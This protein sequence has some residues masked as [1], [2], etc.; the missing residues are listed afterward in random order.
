MLT[1]T[2]KPIFAILAI[3]CASSRGIPRGYY[4]TGSYTA[5]N[6]DNGKYLAH[7]GDGE[8]YRAADQDG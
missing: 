3:I 5:I 2:L 6:I 8:E 1:M 4:G 7:R